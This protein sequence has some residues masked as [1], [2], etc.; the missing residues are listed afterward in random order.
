M[1][2]HVYFEDITYVL[3]NLIFKCKTKNL[4][5]KKMYGTVKLKK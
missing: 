4:C 1:Q 5:K 3:N 2:I